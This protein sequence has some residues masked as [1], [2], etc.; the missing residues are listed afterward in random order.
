MS[1]DDDI[2]FHD[3]GADAPVVARAP[4]TMAEL[5]ANGF[6]SGG[7]L[8]TLAALVRLPDPGDRFAGMREK[9]RDFVELQRRAGACARARSA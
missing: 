9:L 3:L 2:C 7:D 8:E 5:L 4:A 6:P 1:A